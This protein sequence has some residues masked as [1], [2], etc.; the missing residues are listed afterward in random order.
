MAFVETEKIS[1]REVGSSSRGA[2]RSGGAP[3]ESRPARLL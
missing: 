3:V 1:K 2:S